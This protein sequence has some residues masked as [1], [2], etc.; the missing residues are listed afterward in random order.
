MA[1]MLFNRREKT[2][3]IYQNTVELVSEQGERAVWT[4]VDISLQGMQVKGPPGEFFPLGGVV[5]Y[6]ITLATTFDEMSI[7]GEGKVVWKSERGRMGIRFWETDTASMDH[8]RRLLDLNLGDGERIEE[9]LVTF[10]AETKKSTAGDKKSAEAYSLK[11]PAEI[12][13]QGK[14]L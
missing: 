1:K 11:S 7:R 6:L 13:L 5:R 14:G 8:L 10:I 3:V 9:E 12:P 4:I 2:R